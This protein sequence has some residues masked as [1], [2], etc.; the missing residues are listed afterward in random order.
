M[1][2]ILRTDGNA[3][4]TIEPG[5]RTMTVPLG[6]RYDDAEERQR[7]GGKLVSGLNVTLTSL[8]MVAPRNVD[9]ERVALAAV[10][11]YG[12][13]SPILV[14]PEHVVFVPASP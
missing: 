12:T 7:R 2:A 5:Q 3:D 14:D 11:L 4:L 9:L 13:F 6:L 10:A 8:R 1:T